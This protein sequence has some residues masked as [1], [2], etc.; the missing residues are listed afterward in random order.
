MIQ[1]RYHSGFAMEA[2]GELGQADFDRDLPLQP[3]IERTIDDAH[4]P[5]IE[6]FFDAIEPDH[7][8]LP[9]G[10]PAQRRGLS[11]IRA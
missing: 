7:R 10:G 8:A 1:R 11:R 6:A 5:G 3:H 4:A 2:V 9:S